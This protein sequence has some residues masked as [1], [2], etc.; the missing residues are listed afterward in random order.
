MINP[1]KKRKLEFAKRFNKALDL[2]NI[3]PWNQ[4]RVQFVSE[5]F[6][7]THAGAGKW[8]NGSVLPPQ[9]RRREIAKK[10]K[11]N[12]S[13]LE[14]GKEDI[15]AKESDKSNF[16]VLPE[17]NIL[18]PPLQTY[19]ND[20]ELYQFL[21]IYKHYIL[22]REKRTSFRCDTQNKNN[23]IDIIKT[24][25]FFC[26]IDPYGIVWKLEGS[27]NDYTAEAQI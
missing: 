5:M 8:V 24:I 25:S 20:S 7:L 6:N 22:S 11:I 16:E 27:S 4:G 18:K 15:N 1:T 21:Q 14:F 2:I 13:W 9:K 12:Y 23:V 26:F 19:N 10:L 17:Q 3:P